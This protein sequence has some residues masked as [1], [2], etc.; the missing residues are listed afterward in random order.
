MASEPKGAADRR[1]AKG[2]G[3]GP[4]VIGPG[5]ALVQTFDYE[6]GN[7]VICLAKAASLPEIARSSCPLTSSRTPH[8][9]RHHQHDPRQPPV[10]SLI[11]KQERVHHA[12]PQHRSGFDLCKVSAIASR[13][14]C[15]GCERH[16]RGLTSPLKFDNQTPALRP[17]RRRCIISIIPT[18]TAR[19]R[20]GRQSIPFAEVRSS[21]NS[22]SSS[23]SAVPKSLL[24]SLPTL[25]RPRRLRPT[26][27][28]STFTPQP[29]CRVEQP[30]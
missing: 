6:P 28:P 5:A 20:I 27:L 30:H 10:L 11:E 4:A 7:H 18:E 26:T 23:S 3:A 24:R 1:V 19:P 22:S 8:C 2:G 13:R 17:A 21:S 25:P 16:P 9:H 29:A 15:A 14:H 12:Q